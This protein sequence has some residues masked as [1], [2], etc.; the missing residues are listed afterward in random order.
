MARKRSRLNGSPEQHREYAANVL[1]GMLHSLKSALDNLS[2]PSP[3]CGKAFD[4]YSMG[5]EDFGIYQTEY[6]SGR[7]NESAQHASDLK[8]ASRMVREAKQKLFS[9]CIRKSP[10]PGLSGRSSRRRKSR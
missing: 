2:Q 7:M 1:P 5:V 9:A 10:S 3:Y 4:D 8:A 6:V